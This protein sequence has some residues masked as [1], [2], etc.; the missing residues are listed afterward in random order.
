MSSQSGAGGKRYSRSEQ[1]GSM[2]LGWGKGPESLIKDEKGSSPSRGG[3]GEVGTQGSEVSQS[4]ATW[5]CP[6]GTGE[7]AMVFMQTNSGIRMSEVGD[8]RCHSGDQS[9]L[10]PQ[11][12]THN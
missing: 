9:P 4:Q 7:P 12:H 2:A 11:L 10:F 3:V 1:A 6:V 5:P 8:S